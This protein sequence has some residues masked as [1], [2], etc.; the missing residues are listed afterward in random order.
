MVTVFTPTYNRAYILSKLYESLQ[1]QTYKNFEWLIVDDG[2]TDE[3]ENLIK[4][5][6]DD[7]VIAINYIRQQNGGKHRA[8]NRGVE[9][10]KGELFF[11]VDSDDY[12]SEKALERIVYYLDPIRVDSDFVGVCGLKSYFSGEI[13]GGE[14]DFEI[15]DCSSIDFRLRHKIKGDMAEVFKTELLKLYPFPDIEGEKF[16][17]EALVWNQ[18]AQKHKFR[19]FNEKIYF[20]E[21]LPDGLTAKIVKMR[22]NSPK[23][24]LL[25]YSQ[26]CKFKIPF[27]QKIK[28]AI[29]YWRFS[30]NTNDVSMSDKISQIGFFISIISY[31]IGFA[32][33]LR[34]KK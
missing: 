3:T 18:I 10:A 1:K 21:Y 28:A 7:G 5:F 12:L 6:I 17:P 13:V 19:Y 4:G 24:S 32:M 30:F 2:S 15:L 26:L 9:E 8:I 33:Y 11:I 25:Y 20:C 23:A 14:K 34:D 22:M 27:I 29:N 16:C 31:P